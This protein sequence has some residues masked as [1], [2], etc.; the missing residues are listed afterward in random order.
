VILLRRFAVLTLLVLTPAAYAQ[1]PTAITGITV[2]DTAGG[3]TLANA[4]VVI[5]GS[6]IASVEPG[7]KPPAGA[8]VIDGR[9]KFLIPGL[10]D[11]HVHLSWTKES[12]LLLLLANGV[13]GV[14]DLGGSLPEVDAWRTRVATGSLP[15]PRI[16][17]AGPTLNGQKFNQYQMV[18]GTPDETR[19]VVRAL[20]QVGVDF[21]K[22]HRRTVRESYFA[23]ID[24]AKKLELPVVGHI[25]M[26]VTPEEASD[27]G[28]KTI[29]HVV[30][31]FEGTFSAT[32]KDADL[33]AAIRA[34]RLSDEDEKLFARFVKNATVVDPTLYVYSAE[35]LAET[36]LSR[37]VALSYKKEAEKQPKRTP[38]Q[39]EATRE[40]YIEFKEVVRSMHRAGI[41]M[42]T[43]SDIAATRVPG[44]TMHDELT[45]LVDSGLSPMEALQ[46]ATINAARVLNV[47]ADYG[48]I[49]AGKIADMVLLDADPL[50]RIDNT[51]R[52][53]A[54]FSNGK[55]YRRADLD[56]LLRDAEELAKTE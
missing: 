5:Q 56:K 45:A 17:R 33:A 50:L 8:Q 34:W 26:T 20:K 54:V 49:T 3:G 21:I 22:V 11:M 42:V 7:A 38:E 41:M 14:R 46:A 39:I 32:L 2:I 29:E 4:T 18:M 27:A 28:Q 36:P 9:G 35:A 30:T 1:R 16:F 31:I 47:T 13:T 19:G 52:I 23:A 44:F 37:Y 6:R 55:V 25:P 24:E 12:A 48:T 51:R 15:G 10:W 40:A 53:S 43:G